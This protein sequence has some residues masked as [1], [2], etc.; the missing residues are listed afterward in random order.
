MT[1]ISDQITD[2]LS[3]T[4]KVKAKDTVTGSASSNLNQSDFLNLLTQ[5]LQFQDP[6]EPQDN[7]QFVSQLCQFSQLTVS[8]DTY[9]TLSDY[10]G[11]SRAT[12]LVGD[13]VILTDPNDKT[14]AIAGKVDAA[15]LDGSK[16]AIT[17]NGVNY[18]L[19]YLMYAYQEE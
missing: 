4:E 18:P 19:E 16:S 15:Y 11:E 2:L 9:Q 10:A 17:V 1:T 5:Q 12:S 8:T 13:N 7:S 3:N 14:K 6:M